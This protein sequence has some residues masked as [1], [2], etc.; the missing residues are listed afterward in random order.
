MTRVQQGSLNP[1]IHEIEITDR[2][3]RDRRIISLSGELDLMTTPQASACLKTPR[4][5]AETVL[6]LAGVTFI[7]ARGMRFL[8]EAQQGADAEGSSLIMRNPS[9]SVRIMLRVSGVLQYLRFAA[10]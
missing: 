4:P 10:E 8:V 3:D 2:T 5:G 6:D 1:L 9:A 7:D